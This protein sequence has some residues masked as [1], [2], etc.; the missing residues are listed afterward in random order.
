MTLS[1]SD[2]A[3][4]N[5]LKMGKKGRKKVIK[6]RHDANTLCS[7]SLCAGMDL[8]ERGPF[9]FG[10]HTS[11]S[12]PGNLAESS[13]TTKERD[14]LLWCWVERWMEAEEGGLGF[15]ELGGRRAGAMGDKNKEDADRDQM[16]KEN[17]GKKVAG[18]KGVK[19]AQKIRSGAEWGTFPCCSFCED[20]LRQTSVKNIRGTN[21]E[22]IKLYNSKDNAIP[23]E[24][25]IS[26]G[27]FPLKHFPGSV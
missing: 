17:K 21:L 15:A 9:P 20:I 10:S 11:F 12:V 18:T 1:H 2:A 13:C 22:V 6:A 24:C 5:S 4:A 27:T 23:I 19:R 16:Q 3:G 8:Q 26:G 14:F 25:F 7:A